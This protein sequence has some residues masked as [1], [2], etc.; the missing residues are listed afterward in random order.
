APPRGVLEVPRLCTGHATAVRTALETT[1]LRVVAHG[2]NDLLLGTSESDR[3]FEGLLH[4]CAEVGAE[5]V[6]YHARNLPDAP[7]SE[8]RVL[9]ETR[10]LARLALI[11]ERLGVA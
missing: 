10:S 7:S 3:V 4:W 1:R 9:F 2:P 5:V 6:V 11:A 8:Q